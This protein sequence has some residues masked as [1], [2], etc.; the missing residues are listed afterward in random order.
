MYFNHFYKIS[1]SVLYSML[2]SF[3]YLSL[4]LLFSLIIVHYFSFAFMLISV[5]HPYLIA[6]IK[7]SLYC[8]HFKHIDKVLTYTVSFVKFIPVFFNDIIC[9]KSMYSWTSSRSS[10]FLW[11]FYDLLQNITIKHYIS[12]IFVCLKTYSLSVSLFKSFCIACNSFND[13]DICKMSSTNYKWF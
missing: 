1:W 8:F 10:Y 2:T 6:D 7:N 11:S 12:F 3:Y 4:W 9:L 5:S 13:S